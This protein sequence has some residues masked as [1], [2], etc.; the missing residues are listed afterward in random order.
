MVYIKSFTDP[1]YKKNFMQSLVNSQL[2]VLNILSLKYNALRTTANRLSK[3]FFIILRI[4]L[5]FT[6]RCPIKKQL[7]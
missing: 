7:L 4:K 5:F 3:T 6:K 1:H 2:L